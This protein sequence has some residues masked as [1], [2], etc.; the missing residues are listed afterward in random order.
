[1]V[2]GLSDWQVGSQGRRSPHLPLDGCI[3]T[4]AS[5]KPYNLNQPSAV[6]SIEKLVGHLRKSIRLI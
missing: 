1:M 5:I 3:G 2:L 6:N 4:A